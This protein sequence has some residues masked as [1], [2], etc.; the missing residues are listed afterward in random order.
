MNTECPL[1]GGALLIHFVDWR[2]ADQGLIVHAVGLLGTM[3]VFRGT[4]P[5]EVRCPHC[6]ELIDLPA[7]ASD[8][9]AADVVLEDLDWLLVEAQG[10]D[11]S[12]VIVGDRRADDFR[13]EDAEAS[14]RVCRS[15][16]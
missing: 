5:A 13:E 14:N 1:C 9:A 8:R 4:V 16:T 7:R 3:Q 6:R 10:L 12:Q 15:L 2:G 11:L